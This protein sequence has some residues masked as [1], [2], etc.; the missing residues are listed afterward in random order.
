MNIQLLATLHVRILA[1]ALFFGL[2]TTPISAAEQTLRF[3]VVPQFDARRIQ[4]IW[5]PILDNL[6]KQS[7]HH[8]ELIGSPSIPEFE[9]QFMAGDFDFAYMNPYHMLKAHQSQDY[10]PLV[11]D[12][13]RTL[14]G[15]VVVRKDSPIQ[16][17]K[18]LDGKQVA[19]PAPNALGAALIPRAE[20]GE[21]Y[22]INIEPEYVRSHGSVY[23]NV[24][25]GQTVAGG[26]VQKTLQ[27][28]PANVR[29]ALK[30]I[31]KTPQ[32]APHPVAANPRV[33]KATRDKVREA[34]LQLGD[35]QEGRE[36]LAK[37]PMKQVGQ[38]TL[39]DY[40]PLKQMGLDKYY[41]Q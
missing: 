7:G 24:V 12:V 13:G 6:E 40:A 20:F 22:K 16:D 36:L 33:D 3:G 11:R 31:Y 8:F 15:I 38:A 1:L 41:V 26:G 32:V 28:Q 17:V 19:F 9:K 29:D 35:T 30:I 39:E 5:R 23:L 4:S 10:T 21:I 25:T 18:D 37:I 14:F 27:K 2:I 34:F